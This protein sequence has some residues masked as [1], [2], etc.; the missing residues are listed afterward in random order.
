MSA[1]GPSVKGLPWGRALGWTVLFG[2]FA[3]VMIPTLHMRFGVAGAAGPSLMHKQAWY[4]GHFVTALPAAIVGALQFSSGLR[5]AWPKVHR[6]LGRTY[7]V[8]VLPSA[9][10]GFWLACVTD[11]PGSRLPAAILAVL[12]FGFTL[13]G[14]LRARAGDYVSHR[15]LMIRS[16]ALIFVFIWSRI[17]ADPAFAPL[18]AWIKDPNELMGNQAWF[19]ILV[20]I[21]LVEAWL[22]WRP[23]LQGK[24]RA[25]AKAARAA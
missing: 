20:P 16:Y 13:G 21:L 9:V 24:A 22:S 14:W 17:D 8:L 25:T 19:G 23:L 3:Y 10:A 4:W 6:W 11:D 7:V 15:L 12:W 1:T 2:L 18:W 5:A